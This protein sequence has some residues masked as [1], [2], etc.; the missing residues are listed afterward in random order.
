MYAY[1][2]LHNNKIDGYQKYFLNLF[3]IYADYKDNINEVA[4]ALIN[5]ESVNIN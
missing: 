5:I 3:S 2:I 1:Y 4:L